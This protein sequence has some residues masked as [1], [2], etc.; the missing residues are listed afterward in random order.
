MKLMNVIVTGPPSSGKSTFIQ[1][2][3]EHVFHTPEQIAVGRSGRP[4][5]I[6]FGRLTIKPGSFLYLA[7]LPGDESFQ[8]VWERLVDGLLGFVVVFDAG[9]RA[10]LDETKLLIKRLKNLTD[11]PFIVVLNRLESRQAPEASELK[12]ALGISREEQVVCCDI[13]SKG[14]AKEALSAL[15][16][17][18]MKQL[19]KVSA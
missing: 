7:G 12:K 14:G 4:Y 6:E 19:K 1:T 3:S 5:T 15:L 9:S 2:L 17:I 13:L 16:N 18:G 8:F 10:H 11:T